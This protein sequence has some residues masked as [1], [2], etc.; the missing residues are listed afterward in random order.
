MTKDFFV[1][2]DVQFMYPTNHFPEGGLPLGKVI[3]YIPSL[4]SHM[5]K[6]DI[7]GMILKKA[8]ERG[9]IKFIIGIPE[10]TEEDKK[11][12]IELMRKQT[13]NLV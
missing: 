6:S 11:R 1:D 5:G 3:D 4:G 13:E 10:I 8:R 9:D 2:M 7:M 12:R